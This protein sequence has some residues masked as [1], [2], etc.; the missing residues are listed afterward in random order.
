MDRHI[1]DD[2]STSSE[3]IDISWRLAAPVYDAFVCKDRPEDVKLGIRSMAILFGRQTIP[4]CAMA[5]VCFLSLFAYSGMLNG[6]GWPF[7]ASVMI[8]GA[9]IAWRLA[10]TNI[11]RNEDCVRFFLGSTH[12]SL[13]LAVGLAVDAITS[14]V[15]RGVP[16]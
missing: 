13:V 10:N 9:V 3:S 1:R 15:E 5:A 4:L 2:L 6:Q 16:L 11:D 7:F 12:I 8:A 14:R